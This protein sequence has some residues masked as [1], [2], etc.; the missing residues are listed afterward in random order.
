MLCP[1]QRERS[2]LWLSVFDGFNTNNRFS[3]IMPSRYYNQIINLIVI[4][5]S[6]IGIC[7]PA[8]LKLH[9]AENQIRQSAL[10]LT[11]ISAIKNLSKPIKADEVVYF[12]NKVGPILWETV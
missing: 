7:L 12:L 4:R 5:I 10:W 6:Q 1:I 3:V 8:F 9:L 2:I 11:V